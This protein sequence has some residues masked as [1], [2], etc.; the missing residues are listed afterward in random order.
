MQRF[1]Q[2][3]EELNSALAALGIHA[4]FFILLAILLQLNPVEVEAPRFIQLRLGAEQSSDGGALQEQLN[5]EVQVQNVAAAEQEMLPEFGVV[6]EEVLAPS[7][8]EKKE[9]KKKNAPVIMENNKPAGSEF[10]NSNSGQDSLTYL[11]WLQLTVQETS[12]IPAEAR[13]KKI[14]GDAVLRLTFNRAG[15]V[16]SYKLVRKTGSKILD[17]AALEVGKKLG[18][19]PFPKMPDDFE[20]SNK[21]VTYDFPISFKP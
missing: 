14:S 8:V 18:Y 11:E 12:Q 4:A 16:S 10:G 1:F 9:Q 7:P 20:R 13:A 3:K 19:Q 6:A 17:N 21:Q 15:Y 5:E 2:N